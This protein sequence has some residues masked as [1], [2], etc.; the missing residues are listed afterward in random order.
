MNYDSNQTSKNGSYIKS[1][2]WL[3]NKKCTI[4]PQNK[5]DNR[6]FQH[7]IIVPLNDKKIDNQPERIFKIR[8]FINQYNWSEIDFPS[9]Q[10]D[11]NKFET[12]NKSIALNIL[13]I[14]HNIKHSY[15]SK[16]NLTR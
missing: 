13:H 8:P 14:P 15:K 9:H 12:N 16:F 7:A 3:K 5:N 4:N 11:W 2:E 10:K 1:L 6:C